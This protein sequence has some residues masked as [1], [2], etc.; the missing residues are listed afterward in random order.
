MRRERRVRGGR[1]GL[2]LCAEASATDDDAPTAPRASVPRRAAL[3]TA[4][5]SLAGALLAELTFRRHGDRDEEAS[6]ENPYVARANFT[7]EAAKRAYDR[8]SPRIYGG[9]DYLAE[10]EAELK[11]SEAESAQR[12]VSTENP[13]SEAARLQRAMSIYAG[14]FSDNY[15]SDRTKDLKGKTDM[16]MASLQKAAG[17]RD[18]EQQAALLDRARQLYNEYMA[19]AN[20]HRQ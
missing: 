4:A 8:Y 6:T 13:K 9:K 20:L 19:G 17:S 7:R 14:V 10:V 18:A 16:M 5:L 1:R 11:S 12:L 3:R 15:E 2:P